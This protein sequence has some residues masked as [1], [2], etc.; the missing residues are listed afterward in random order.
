MFRTVLHACL[1]ETIDRYYQEVG[2]AGRDGR[3][4][5]AYLCSGPQDEQIAESLSRVVLIGDDL[6]WKRWRSMMHGA[7]H[8][9]GF[10]YRVR[11]STLPTYL[12]DGYGRSAQWNVRTLT[13]MAQAGVI[14]LRAP[15]WTPNP[16]ASEEANAKDRDDFY[17]NVDDFLEFDLLNGELL[18]EQGWK[19]ALAF[20]RQEVRTAQHEALHAVLSLVRGQECVGRGW[21]H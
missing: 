21:C 5:I 19:T 13:L 11:K 18:G 16:D 17:A 7:E 9:T 3:P 15:R 8:L 1:P 2:R 6:G 10:R 12:T 4:S 20:I 14:G